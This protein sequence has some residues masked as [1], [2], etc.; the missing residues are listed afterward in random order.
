[1]HLYWRRH[2]WWS[3]CYYYCHYYYYPSLGS[4][5]KISPC[6][7]PKTKSPAPLAPTKHIVPY[8]NFGVRRGGEPPLFGVGSRPRSAPVSATPA[9]HCLTACGQWGVEPLQRTAS[10]PGGN[11][12]WNSCH[13]PPHCLGAMGSQYTASLP[14]GSGQYNS[15]IC[16]AT[17]LRGGERWNSCNA[18]PHCSGAVGCGT[19][20]THCLT[21]WGRWAVEL[22]S[23]TA[24]LPGG[25]G[26]CN[27]CNALPHRSGAV[28]SG[29]P[30]MR[31][32]ISWGDGESC[33][34]GGRCLKSGTPP[35]HCHTAWGQWAVQLMQCT[36]SLPGGSGQWNSCNA[37]PH[38]LGSVGNAILAV[39]CHTAWGRRTVEILQCAGP[40]AG[41]TGVVWCGV[42]WCGV[43]WCGV[44]KAL[45]PKGKRP[46]CLPTGK[47]K[48]AGLC[49]LC[50]RRA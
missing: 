29:T 40:P 17:L 9:M 3:C 18:L 31:G 39:H 41:G 7:M 20:A 45:L 16:T 35:M 38:C 43:V 27:S 32:P 46:G 13:A 11:G 2:W 28:G 14:G 47:G 23:C 6:R 5:K 49:V 42:V 34:G 26:S 44:P 10:L 21:A 19:L 33:P 1:M 4:N 50:A 48:R 12:Q 25:S 8:D 30:V 15:Y 24:T 37:L 22:L 36:T